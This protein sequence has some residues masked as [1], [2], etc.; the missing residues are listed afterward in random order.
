MELELLQTPDNS[1]SSFCLNF[2]TEKEDKNKYQ[3]SI[4][5]PHRFWYEAVIDLETQAFTRQLA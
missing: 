3:P 1:A 2:Y 4:H 5:S